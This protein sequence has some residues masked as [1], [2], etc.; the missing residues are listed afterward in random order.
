MFQGLCKIVFVLWLVLICFPASGQSKEDPMDNLHFASFTFA[1][2]IVPKGAAEDH[3]SHKNH[4]VPNYGADYLY[5]LVP[6]WELA[7]YTILHT[8][9]LR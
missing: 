4:L 8:E 7:F 6:K 2:C 5:R 1:S 3:L 9:E